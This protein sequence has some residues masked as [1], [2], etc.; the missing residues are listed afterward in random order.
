MLVYSFIFGSSVNYFLF[1][2]MVL[3]KKLLACS[4]KRCDLFGYSVSVM[5]EAQTN[6][7][8]ATVRPTFSSFRTVILHFEQPI[9]RFHR[10]F[11]CYET[12]AVSDLQRPT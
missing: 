12:K 10:F 4:E 8:T 9:D 6:L 11:F 1:F 3:P 7:A 5:I 2:R